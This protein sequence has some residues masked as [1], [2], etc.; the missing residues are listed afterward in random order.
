MKNLSSAWQKFFKLVHIVAASIWLGS[1]ISSFMIL[2]LHKN[3]S[4]EIN[5]FHFDVALFRISE[6]LISGS[7]FVVLITAIIFSLFTKYG[8]FRYYWLTIKWLVL[9]ALLL[10]HTGL[11]APAIHGMVALSDSGLA[12]TTGQAIYA[13][14]YAKASLFIVIESS[15]VLLLFIVSILKPFGLA[16]WAAKEH[17]PKKLVR[18]LVTDITIL[19]FAFAT[20]NEYQFE[21]VRNLEIKNVDFA[22]HRSDTYLGEYDFQFTY[23]VGV[24]VEDGI[25]TDIEIL[26][27][28]DNDHSRYAEGIVKKIIEKQR[29]DVD[30][31]TGA[32]STSVAIQKAIENALTK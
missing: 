8:F 7:F 19:I 32:T 25:L 26:E 27:N 20:Y 15:L 31:I 14:L 16:K 5:L 4:P 30:A 10:I 13:S 6:S 21:K 11:Y 28:R 22:H 3:M 12:I 17:K 9:I 24:V 18:I 29:I 1:A 23:K 2:Q